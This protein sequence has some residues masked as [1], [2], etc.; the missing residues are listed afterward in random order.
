MRSNILLQ[1]SFVNKSGD[2]DDND[3]CQ[4][5]LW[6]GLSRERLQQ[7]GKYGD[8]RAESSKNFSI[9]LFNSGLAKLPVSELGYIIA[10]VIIPVGGLLMQKSVDGNDEG[11]PT[12]GRMIVLYQHYELT[13]TARESPMKLTLS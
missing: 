12:P 3:R 7:S 8:E 5:A 13:G 4:Q 10:A 9:R 2:D 6:I 11:D 1:E